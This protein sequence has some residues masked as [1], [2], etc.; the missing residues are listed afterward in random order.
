[1]LQEFLREVSRLKESVG[2]DGRLDA[3]SSDELVECC[4]RIL[5]V[6]HSSHYARPCDVYVW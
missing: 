3:S 2:T 6:H 4:L 1:M 5:Q